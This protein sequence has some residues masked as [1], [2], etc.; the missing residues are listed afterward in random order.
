MSVSSCEPCASATSKSRPFAQRRSERR[1]GDQRA[2]LPGARAT[3]VLADHLR[4]EPVQ[5]EQLE[6]LRVVARGDLDLVS[7]TPKDPDQ[8]SEDEHV[9]ARRHVDPDLHGAALYGGR[10]FPGSTCIPMSCGSCSRF[11][12]GSGC[13]GARVRPGDSVPDP[14]RA[15]RARAR[16]RRRA[17]AGVRAAAGGHP[18]RVPAAAA[19]L[20]GLL[21]LRARPAHESPAGPLLAI[22]L[23]AATMVGVAASRTGSSTTSRGRRRSCS[24]RSFR[25]PTR[26]PPPR[27]AG[28]WASRGG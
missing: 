23:V 24:A 6:R 26:S 2:R 18:D 12:W 20:V 11:S 21:H 15:G 1:S 28:A 4:L 9:R 16:V 8:R 13:P 5:L 25:P 22:G 14:A 3:A 7:S 10:I 19:L 27:S 17:P